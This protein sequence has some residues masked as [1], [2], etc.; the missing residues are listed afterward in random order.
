MK[1]VEQGFIDPQD[2]RFVTYQGRRMLRV[3]GATGEV[4]D[5]A[6]EAT[7]PEPVP[8]PEATPPNPG[9]WAADLEARF[10]DPAARAAADAYLR[11]VWQPRVTQLEQSQLPEGAAKLWSDINDPEKAAA[12]YFALG[13]E[14]FDPELAEILQGS[15]AD[16]YQDPA[17]ETP[18]PEATPEPVEAERDPEVQRLIDLEYERSYK[19]DVAAAIAEHEIP[20]KFQDLIHPMIVSAQGRIPD[21]AAALKAKLE[22]AGVLETPAAPETP[23]PPP[24]AGAVPPAPPVA[25]NYGGDLKEAI[26]DF[27]DQQQN[28][29]PPPVGTV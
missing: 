2:P 10:P 11:E 28:V 7:T 13:G 29:A 12:T 16:Y 27:F 8:T 5:P 14:L 4:P 20:E 3:I 9:P 18:D 17:E 25:K 22:A 6:P 21:A 24:V 19:T 15:A 23:A 1:P 26:N